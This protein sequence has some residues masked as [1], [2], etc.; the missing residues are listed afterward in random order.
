MLKLNIQMKPIAFAITYFLAL[1]F[2]QAQSFSTQVLN[3][4]QFLSAASLTQDYDGDGDLDIIATRWSPTGVYLLENDETKQFNA[5]AII[6]DDLNFYMSDIDAADFDNDGDIDYLVS[7]TGVDDGELA[8]FQRLDDGTYVKWTIATNKDF[9][10]ADVGDFNGDGRVDIVAVGLVNSDQRGRLYINQGNLFFTEQIIATNRIW[11]SVDAADVDN[12]GD[13]DI[14]FGG[15]ASALGNPGEGARLILNDGTGNFTESIFLHCW[16]DNHNDCGGAQNIQIVDL[17][18][19]GIQDILA[20]SL[21]GTGGIYWLD[22]SNG[23]N[24]IRIDDDN[25]IDLGGHFVVF[26]IDGNGLPD[27]I[28]QSE[29]RDRVSV[30][31]QTSPVQFSREYIDL[32]W[33]SCCNPSTKMSFGDLDN[34]GDIDLVFPE[35]GNVDHDF[36][37]FENINGHLYKHQIFGELDGVRIPK[38]VDW[39]N[40]GDLDIFATVSSGTTG[41]TEDEVILYENIDGENFINWRLNDALN[42]AADI[43]FADIDGDGDL[44]AFATARDANDLVW[45]RNDGF[46]ANWAT[47]IIFPEANAPLGVATGDLDNN[48]GA[49]AV[50]CSSGDDKV[51][52]FLNDGSGTFS[53]IVVDPNIDGP[54]EAEIADLDADGDLDIAVVATN[55]ANTLVIYLN[56]GNASFT[57]QIIYTGK[58]GRDIEIADWDGDGA[59]DILISLYSTTP[60]D[61]PQDILVFI[62]DGGA[63]F[64]ETA[65]VFGAERTQGFRV[66]DLDLDGDQDLVLGFDGTPRVMAGINTAS[67]IELVPLSSVSEGN[68]YGIDVG[69]INNDNQPDVVYA[70]FGRDD[71]MLIS[72]NCLVAPNPIISVEDATCEEDNGTATVD[73]NI[74]DN[75]SFSWNNG[76]TTAVISDLSAGDY[77]VTVTDSNGCISS[78]SVTIN[79]IPLAEIQLNG[80]NTTCGAEDGTAEVDI[81]SGSF[82]AINWNT[83]DTTAMIENLAGG[84]YSVVVTDEYGCLQTDTINIQGLVYPVIN[85]GEDVTIQDGEIVTLDPGGE[86]LS[87]SWSSGETTPTISASMPGTYIVTATN[88]DGCS[89]S[90]QITITIITEVDEPDL[91]QA[92]TI[93]PNPTEGT[94]T[95]KRNNNITLEKVR[96]LNLTGQELYLLHLNDSRQPVHLDLSNLPAGN[97]IL[98]LQTNSG[99]S[100]KMIVKH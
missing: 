90:D 81:L 41:D 52:G 5:T 38:M 62:N 33:D 91:L 43:E 67:G 3:K 71:L 86:N 100:S 22:G 69:D 51:F 16:S 72:I 39:D 10:M 25:T 11:G 73:I 57:E 7:F 89:T 46:Q 45:L 88:A 37:W 28:R 42:Y 50:I 27:V 34:D 8:W 15:S 9:I 31:Y 76:D 48:N 85:L 64:E 47:T 59:L 56:N 35:Q 98:Q 80:T 78:G 54:R 26:D 97:Y 23:F 60:N 55:G 77:T 14:A 92:L 82:S 6:E 84:T 1:F 32:N 65:L 49:D 58:S 83:G 93:Y 66:A 24:Q 44:D 21:T 13:L 94:V 30:L 68:I 61:P 79:T 40:D 2:L 75:P 96:L 20:F 87:Y 63:N 95:I 70:D 36:S 18:A 53:P 19:D 99:N 74:F 4:G 29:G 17:N 12:D